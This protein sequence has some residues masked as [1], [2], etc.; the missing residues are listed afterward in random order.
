MRKR[1]RALALLLSGIM[2]ASVFPLLKPDAVEESQTSSWSKNIGSG[3]FPASYEEKLASLR[4]AHPNWTF[5]PL[6]TGLDFEEVVKAEYQDRH[7]LIWYKADDL[8]KSQAEGDYDAETGNYVFKDSTRWFQ[9]TEDL[10][11]YFI[12]PRNWLNEENIF[13]FEDIS[14]SSQTVSGVEAIIAGSFMDGKTVEE[15]IEIKETEEETEEKTSKKKSS[16]K[17]SNK[18]TSESTEETAVGQSEEQTSSAVVEEVTEAETTV[19]AETEASLEEPVFQESLLNLSASKKKSS[20]KTESKGTSYA[21]AIYDAGV[22]AGISPYYLASKILQEVGRDGSDSVSGS[23]GGI[24]GIYNF[25]N[26]GASDGTDPISN[27]LNWASQ[28]GDYGRPWT[29]PEK[30]IKGG[31]SYIAD[32]F[33]GN[34]QSTGY[35]LRFNVNPNGSLYSNQYMT[36]VT[37]AQQESIAVR[38]TYVASGQLE[39]AKTF[40]IPVY[41]N[42]PSLED[43]IDSAGYTGDGIAKEDAVIYESPETDSGILTTIPKGEEMTLIKGVRNT[44]SYSFDRLSELYF[45]EVSYRANNQTYHGYVEID[46]VYQPLTFSAIKGQ[47]LDLAGQE[48][49]YY[50]SENTGVASVSED[51]ILTLN[52]PGRTR[53]F[54]FNGISFQTIEVRCVKKTDANRDIKSI[55]LEKTALSVRNGESYQITTNT[56]VRYVSS[57][58]SVAGVT[59]KGRIVARKY[60]MT[61][62]SLNHGSLLSTIKVTVQPEAVSDFTPYQTSYNQIRF[63]WTPTSDAKGYVIYRRKKGEDYELYATIKNPNKKYFAD[64]DVKEGTTYTYKMVAYGS[65]REGKVY[66]KATRV[67]VVAQ[68]ACPE[69]LKV[70]ITNQ[71]NSHGPARH[72]AMILSWDQVRGADGYVIYRKTDDAKYKKVTTIYYNQVV[73]YADSR[74]EEGHTYTYKIQAY[75]KEKK[76]HYSEESQEVSIGMK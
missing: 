58:G 36:N 12:D 20:K 11:T 25:Y 45:Y 74:I 44:D 62:I 2:A 6:Y 32:H 38:N 53:I 55:S 5:R 28:V 72:V 57:K 76:M 48:G 23:H 18:A 13:C 3:G 4:A 59:K 49:Y 66:S 24:T 16:S 14:Y 7:C 47:T 39:K 17:K 71:L 34:G 9:T 50:Q 56:D 35:L 75:V 64:R 19:E 10:A 40:L 15:S 27:G 37:G 69:N 1:T 46:Q 65:N 52:S 29:S 43:E 33:L 21:Q 67:S 26:I 8:L 61:V 60:G 22:A 41:D 73:S 54:I 51:G 42:M 63:K 70:E 68:T 31:A 30:S